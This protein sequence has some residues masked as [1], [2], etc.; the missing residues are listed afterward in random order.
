MKRILYIDMDGVVADF[1]AHVHFLG[2][3]DPNK[4]ECRA[5]EGFFLNLPLVEGALEALPI[6]SEKYDMYFL[7]TPQWSNPNSWKEK[8]EWVEKHYGELMHKRLILTHNKSLLKGDYLIDDRIANGVDGF[9]GEHIH[10]GTERF[11]NWDSIV[12]YL[13]EGV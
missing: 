2:E 11:P 10:F 12:S 3:R 13:M 9:E 5:P 4:A 8:R 1:D 6:L 7:S